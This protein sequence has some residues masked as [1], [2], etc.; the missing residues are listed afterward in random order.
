MLDG[1]AAYAPII[2]V[3]GWGGIVALAVWLIFTGRLI[4][5]ATVDKVLQQAGDEASRWRQAYENSEAARTL[6]RQTA[7][8]ALE[9][10]QTTTAVVKALNEVIASKQAGDQ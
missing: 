2:G 8:K 7:M 6:D 3:G 5:R 4:P 10:T 1:L 9:G